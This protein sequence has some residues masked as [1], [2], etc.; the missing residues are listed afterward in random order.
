MSVV[1]SIKQHSLTWGTYCVWYG[2]STSCSSNGFP[3]YSTTY[4]EKCIRR[5]PSAHSSQPGYFVYKLLKHWDKSKANQGDSNANLIDIYILIFYS[6]RT[7]Q[8]MPGRHQG[9]KQG[10]GNV[11]PIN[12]QYIYKKNIIIL[13][14]IHCCWTIYTLHYSVV[15]WLSI[16]N[17]TVLSVLVQWWEGGPTVPWVSTL[18][19]W[20]PSKQKIISQHLISLAL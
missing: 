6:V 3:V 9:G 19:Q 11:S 4:K 18:G 15:Y 7:C 16:I 20:H 17:C 10:E 12:Q 8:G 5:L 14:W 13:K 1:H 2:P